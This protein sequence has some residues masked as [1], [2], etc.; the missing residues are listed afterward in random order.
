ML[1]VLSGFV[2]SVSQ[3]L[4]KMSAMRQHRS[5]VKEY[6]NKYVLIGYGL[7]FGTTLIN[8]VAFMYVP[9][10]IVPIVSTSSYVF[11]VILSKFILRESIEWNKWTGIAVIVLG[12]FIF[13]I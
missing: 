5:Y 4:L 1:V 8:I 6:L 10:K 7:L 3:V 11:V 13:N 12:I 9:Y 2:A